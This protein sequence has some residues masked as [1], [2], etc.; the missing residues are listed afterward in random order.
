[1]VT[2]LITGVIIAFVCIQPGSTNERFFGRVIPVRVPGRDRD[3]MVVA[4]VAVVV[5]VALAWKTARWRRWRG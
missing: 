2:D 3:Q 1:V 4:V 5:A